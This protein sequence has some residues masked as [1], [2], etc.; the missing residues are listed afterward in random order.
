MLDV[1]YSPHTAI[2]NGATGCG[3][4]FQIMKMLLPGG[5]YYNYFDVVIVLCPTFIHNSAYNMYYDVTFGVTKRNNDL[6]HFY[7]VNHNDPHGAWLVN[8][9][10]D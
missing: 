3:K 10:V 7:F 1:P 6:T 5:E 9:D 2:I 8:P 4:T